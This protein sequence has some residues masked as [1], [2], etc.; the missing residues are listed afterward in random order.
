MKRGHANVW[1]LKTI[2]EH[3]K[4]IVALIAIQI[5]CGIL[6]SL[7]PRYF[8]QLVTLVID[9]ADG[10]MMSRGIPVMGLLIVIY[11]LAALV[12]SIGGYIGVHFSSTFL[13]QLQI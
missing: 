8:Q 7:Q 9:G 3:G 6:I 10:Q 4:A 2:S 13:K 12:Q 11:L 1:L 5:V